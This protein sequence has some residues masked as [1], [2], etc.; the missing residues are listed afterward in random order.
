MLLSETT[1][2]D[3][4]RSIVTSLDTKANCQLGGQVGS[5]QN[6]IA[7]LNTPKLAWILSGND[8]DLDINNPDD[9][10]LLSIGMSPQIR[11]SLA[12]IIC[13]FTVALQ[14]MNVEGKYKS[15]LL[16][17]EAT[18]LYLDDLDHNRGSSL[19]Q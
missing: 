12:P 13:I 15:F 19:I 18:T 16:L 14:Q 5:L 3:Y 2:G 11:K 7:R 9:P 6:V 4:I 10:K 17:D 8:F 1:C